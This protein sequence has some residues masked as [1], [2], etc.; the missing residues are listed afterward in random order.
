MNIIIGIDP[1]KRM[2]LAVLSQ[3]KSALLDSELFELVDHSIYRDAEVWGMREQL[4]KWFYHSIDG[5]RPCLKLWIEAPDGHVMGGKIVLRQTRHGIR[6]SVQ[7]HTNVNSIF[8]LGVVAGQVVGLCEEL[9]I[10]WGF[11]GA[12]EVKRL[13]TGDPTISKAKLALYLESEGYDIP[14]LPSGKP[15]PEGVDALAIALAGAKKEQP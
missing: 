8:Q 15:D 3:A 14:R 9:G 6:Q 5:F 1:G 7:H 2:G 11:I 13:V 12:Q 10:R 4:S